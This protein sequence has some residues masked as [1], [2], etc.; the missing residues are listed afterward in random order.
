VLKTAQAKGSIPFEEVALYG[1]QLHAVVPEAKKYQKPVQRILE[2]EGI[3]VQHVEWI[4]P[5][6]EDVF[7]STVKTD[8]STDRSTA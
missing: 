7:I 3:R 6:L 8:R 5:S 1:A 2:K 4:A